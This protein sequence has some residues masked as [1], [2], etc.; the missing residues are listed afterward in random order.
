MMNNKD[1]R[2][3]QIAYRADESVFEEDAKS[4]L[5]LFSIDLS[6]P[7]TLRI[8]GDDS[9]LNEVLTAIKKYIVE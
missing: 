9:K 4:I 1:R 5:G 2:D 7:V 6:K 8:N 3:A